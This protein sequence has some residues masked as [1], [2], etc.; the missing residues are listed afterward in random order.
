MTR[1]LATI[2]ADIKAARARLV[3]LEREKRAAI[4]AADPA[5][6][7]ARLAKAREIA[8]RRHNALPPMTAEQRALYGKIRYDGGAARA[9]ALKAVGV[10]A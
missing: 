4:A 1:P 10:L 6:L 5:W 2:E 9:D 7:A 8:R 3:E